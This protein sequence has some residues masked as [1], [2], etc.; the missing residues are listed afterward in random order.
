MVRQGDYILFA[1][2]SYRESGGMNDCA[3]WFESKTAALNF[4][5]ESD[6]CKSMDW[7]QILDM[8][9]GEYIEGTKDIRRKKVSG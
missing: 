4:F 2:V 5:N 1:G 7:Y 9:S 8:E 3:G 6:T